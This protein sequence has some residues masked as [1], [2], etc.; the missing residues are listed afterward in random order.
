MNFRNKKDGTPFKVFTPF[1]DTE[2]TYLKKFHPKKSLLKMLKEKNYFNNCIEL[3][4]Y[5]QKLV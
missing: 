5:Y 4:K 1:G 2:R 3:R